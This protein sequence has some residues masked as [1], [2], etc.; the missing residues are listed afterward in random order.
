[1]KRLGFLTAVVALALM[2]Y[3]VPAQAFPT[4]DSGIN[5][6]YFTNAESLDNVDGSFTTVTDNAG[7]VVVTPTVTVGDIFYGVLRVQD[8]NLGLTWDDDNNPD[9]GLD[10]LT[11]YF[12]TQVTNITT[13]SAGT[14]ITHGAA[15]SADTF[16]I[17]SANDIAAGA[18]MKLFADSGSSSYTQD[19]VGGQSVD[20]ANATDGSHWATFG[21]GMGSTYYYSH[22]PSIVPVNPSDNIGRTWFG[23]DIVTIGGVAQNFSGYP[24]FFTDDSGEY[25]SNLGGGGFSPVQMYGHSDV[26][27]ADGSTNWMFDSDDP[28]V[29]V[30]PEPGTFLLLGSGLLGAALIRR[31]MKKS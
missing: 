4:L 1:M 8:V 5:K 22:S 12:R 24:F 23:L 14:H 20:I 10:T 15:T 29:I 17:F 6:L 19:S 28:A 31:K 9:G 25:E 3:S 27:V 13:D 26:T 21:L 11:G 2:I 30:T 16:G 7:N 18:V